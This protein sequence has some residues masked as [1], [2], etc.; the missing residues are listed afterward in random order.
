LR[1]RGGAVSVNL[2]NDQPWS[3]RGTPALA[4]AGS[5]AGSQAY[6]AFSAYNAQSPTVSQVF[7]LTYPAGSTSPVPS[8]LTSP[9]SSYLDEKSSPLII[10]VTGDFEGTPFTS[11]VTAWRNDASIP[12]GFFDAYLWDTAESVRKIFTSYHFPAADGVSPFDLAG[13]GT[14]AGGVWIDEQS[15]RSTRRV[16]WVTTNRFPTYLPVLLR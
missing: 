6:L 13:N 15:S 12:G 10:P 9:A 4:A 5:G 14:I 11:G 16:P 3:L 2:T 7:N 8:Q 1:E